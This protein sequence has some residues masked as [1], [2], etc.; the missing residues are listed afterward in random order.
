MPLPICS[1]QGGAPS[2]SNQWG[3]GS[4][5]DMVILYHKW[6]TGP[7]AL[8]D[9]RRYPEPINTTILFEEATG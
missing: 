9:R 3:I 6:C 4:D 8:S 2:G 7:L 5:V 1:T